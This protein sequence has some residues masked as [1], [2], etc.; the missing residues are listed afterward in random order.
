MF[1]RVP[2]HAALTSVPLWSLLRGRLS[3]LL[4]AVGVLSSKASLVLLA[5]A[6]DWKEAHKQRLALI[7]FLTEEGGLGTTLDVS[8]YRGYDAD[9][10][11]S[12]YL[13]LPQVAVSPFR[14]V[15][16]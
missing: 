12:K 9:N 10:T 16:G 2:G 8:R 6:G 14:P 11:V 4:L 1:E 7:D 5:H 13:N 15:A 3:G